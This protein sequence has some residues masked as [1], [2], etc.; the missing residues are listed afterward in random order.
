MSNRFG[1]PIAV[2]MIAI[3]V[4]LL[5]ATAAWIT[6]QSTERFKQVSIDREEQSNRDQS[7]ARAN[8]VEELFRASIEKSK[9]IASLLIS[10][11]ANSPARTTSVDLTFG[12]DLDLVSL[13]VVE[14]GKKRNPDWLVINEAYLADYKLDKRFI[15]VLREIQATKKSFVIDALFGEQENQVMIRNSTVAGGVPLL[16]IGFPLAKNELGQVTHVVLADLRLDRFQKAFTKLSERQIFMIDSAGQVLAHPDEQVVVLKSDSMRDHAAVRAALTSKVSQGQIRFVDSKTGVGYTASYARTPYGASV[17]A[18]VSN[19]VILEAARAVE[20]EAYYI[21]GRVLSIALFAIFLFSMTLT[22]PIEKLVDLT[23]SV[24]RGRFN[25]R[26]TSASGDEVGRLGRAFNSMIQGLV[27]RDRVKQL[28]NKFH[29]SQVTEDLLK[30]DVH[31]GGAKKQVTVF[32]SDIRDFTKYSESHTPEEVVEMLNEYFQTMVKIINDHGGIVDKFIG[33][34]IM[35]VWGVP[36]SKIGDTDH[37][38]RACLDMRKALATLNEKRTKRGHTP[39]R[40]GMGLHNG[41]VISGTIGS[42]ERMEYTVIGDTVNQASRIE[43]STKALGVDLLLSSNVA[44]AV[45]EKFLVEPAGDVEVKGKSE[46]LRL[47]KVLGYFD[48]Q[49]NLVLVRTEYSDFT[50]ESA[51]KVKIAI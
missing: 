30:R 14:R 2:K 9:I 27:E 20:R 6:K 47:Y 44:E 16:T 37:A 26:W 35:A 25:V 7:F 1:I 34:A 21:T 24:A 22:A 13:E 19:E 36:Q 8:E 43:S 12:R 49:K 46:P 18:M 48:G 4:L 31:L 38:V 50:A 40:I 39:I 33:D 51:D 5:A 29:G 17:I 3:T 10:T 11:N 41:E 42:S 15:D 32:F 23:D 45:K 28:F